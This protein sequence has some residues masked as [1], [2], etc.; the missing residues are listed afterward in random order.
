M[1][2]GT[3]II[4]PDLLVH[5][6][7]RFGEF[8]RFVG[9]ACQK[10]LLGQKDTKRRKIVDATNIRRICEVHSIFL[11]SLARPGA[12]ICDEY[13]SQNEIGGKKTPK[14]PLAYSTNMRTTKTDIKRRQ[15]TRSHMRRI[16]V[17]PIS[18]P[19]NGWQLAY[20][21]HPRC[22]ARHKCR[23]SVLLLAYATHMRRICGPYFCSRLTLSTRFEMPHLCM[24]SFTHIWVAIYDAWHLPVPNIRPGL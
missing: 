10:D 15:K 4:S 2:F 22:A 12:R 13:A 17:Q 24:H 19:P 9:S 1:I 8:C 21:S 6:W 16:C 5:I 20:S 3:D 18:P 11:L 14:D 7:H 23:Q